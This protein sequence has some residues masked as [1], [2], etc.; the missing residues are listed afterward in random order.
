MCKHKFQ[1]FDA[2]SLFCERCGERK[3]IA[4]EPTPQIV[5]V[6]TVPYV[7]QYP[8]VPTWP[9]QPTWWHPQPWPHYQVWCDTGGSTSIGPD[10]TFILN[11]GITYDAES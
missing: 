7:P 6:P 3:V 1:K 11:G 8:Y 2:T 4:A 10:S 5:Y 9:F